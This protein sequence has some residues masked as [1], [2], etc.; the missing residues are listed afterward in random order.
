MS[1][2]DN[3]DLGEPLFDD[4]IVDEDINAQL[5][6]R[7]K[8]LAEYTQYLGLFYDYIWGKIPA[9]AT[10]KKFALSHTSISKLCSTPLDFYKYVIDSK[11]CKRASGTDAMNVGTIVDDLVL[12]KF[13]DPMEYERAGANIAPMGAG[14]N[15]SGAANKLAY[16]KEVER[17][18][19]GNKKR[20]VVSPSIWHKGEQAAYALIGQYKDP[21]DGVY[22]AWNPKAYNLINDNIYTKY[23]FDYFDKELGQQIAGEIDLI[24]FDKRTGQYY[25]VDIKSM[26]KTDPKSVG[27]RIRDRLLP[28]Q[29]AIYQRA[30]LAK[31][32]IEVEDFYFIATNPDGN[33]Y[34][35]KLGYS[36]WKYGKELLQKGLSR[37]ASCAMSGASAFIASHEEGE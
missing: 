13:C 17:V 33:S 9:P 25:L 7:P 23:W 10:G 26:D 36:E 11:F 31:L 16:Q 19:A 18:Q 14:F 21:T 30:V 28:L 29:A 35:Y 15:R 4:Y 5:P 8:S 22:K 32:G 12:L 37:F 24:G 27:Y 6:D 34:I 20:Q 2:E 1:Y 3:E